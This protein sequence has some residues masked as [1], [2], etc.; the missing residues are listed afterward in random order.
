ET[1]ETRGHRITLRRSPNG[2]AVLYEGA[3]P[4]SVT[5]VRFDE[6]AGTLAFT[7]ETGAGPVA[8]EGVAGSG[9]LTGTVTDTSGAH[10]LN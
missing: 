8:F 6:A 2:N 10:A 9:A 7:A 3:A 4:A 5:L 1:R